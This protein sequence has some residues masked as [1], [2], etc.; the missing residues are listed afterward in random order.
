M[1]AGISGFVYPKNWKSIEAFC[2]HLLRP[3]NSFVTHDVRLHRS[4]H[5]PCHEKTI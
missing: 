5:E 3:M 4:R 2:I 1:G